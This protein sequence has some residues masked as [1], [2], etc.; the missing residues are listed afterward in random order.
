MK[1]V[2]VSEEAFQIIT[3]KAETEGL[4]ATQA[5]YHIILESGRTKQA[6]GETTDEETPDTRTTN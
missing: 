5:L 2:R 3:A 4:S 6:T 1:K